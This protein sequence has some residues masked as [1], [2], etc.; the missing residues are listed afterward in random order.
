MPRNRHDRSGWERRKPLT[1][2]VL[3][4]STLAGLA[5]AAQAPDDRPPRSDE[6]PAGVDPTEY[7]RLRRP[8]TWQDLPQF[9]AP[10]SLSGLSDE[11]ANAIRRDFAERGRIQVQSDRYLDYDE[12]RNIIYSNA[13]TRVRFDKY[14]LEADRMLVH[15]PLQ[16][17]QAEGNVILRAW[18]DPE[19]KNKTDEIYCNSIVF[20]YKYYQGAASEA[21]GQHDMVYFKCVSSPSGLPGLQLI[22]RDEAIF[23]NAQFTTCD[24]PVPHYSAST[25]DGILIANDRIFLRNAVIRVRN[26]PVLWLPAYS[27]SINETMPWHITFGNTSRLG[28]YMNIAYNFWHY[29][30]EP[31][32]EKKDEYEV[33]DHGHAQARLDLFSRRGVGMGFF[34]NYGFDFEKHEGE[35]AAYYLPSDRYRQV[36]GDNNSSRWQLF[37]RHRSEIRKNLTFL[38]NVD[39][40]SDPEFYYDLS[41]PM[42]KID[43]GRIPERRA[44]AALTYWK[45]DYTARALFE[46]KQR[47]TRD[48]ITNTLEPTD[49]DRDYDLFP[50]DP[51]RHKFKDSQGLPSSRYGTVSARMPQLTFGTNL[52]RIGGNLPLYYM[53]DINAFNNLDKGLNFRSTRDD[54]YVLGFDLYQQI[55]YLF[56]LSERYTLLAQLG[57]GLGIEQRMDNSWNYR[58]SDFFLPDELFPGPLGTHHPRRDIIFVDPDTFVTPGGRVVSLRDVTPGFVYADAQLRA[59][60]RFTDSLTGNLNYIFREGTKNSLSQFYESIGN[61]TARVDL[62]DYRLRTNWLYGDLTY[63]LAYPDITTQLSAG[64]NLQ[65]RSD[66]FANQLIQFA[67]FGTQFRNQARTFRLSGTLRYEQ[68]QIRNIENP[69]QYQRDMAIAGLTAAYMPIHH[70]WWVEGDI[71]AIKP[72]TSDPNPAA[73]VPPP[74][75]TQFYYFQENQTDVIMDAWVGRKLSDKWTTEV[76]V[77]YHQRYGGLRDFRWIF[78][79][80][81]HDAVAQVQLRYR[82]SYLKNQPPDVGV[83]FN[84]TFKLPGPMETVVSPRANTLMMEQRAIEI[85]EDNLSQAAKE[86]A[87]RASAAPGSSL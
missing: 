67:G 1:L 56:K 19:L 20:N 28:P 76:G 27:R 10:E 62:Y 34:Y 32:F 59:R 33:R 82:R 21:R 30:Y 68:R 42:E 4:F 78:S 73:H 50:D 61:K 3:V 13:R 64:R 54:S 53:L 2:L 44:R 31:S 41:D 87:T 26:I 40:I 55:S 69:Y 24:F 70:R 9:L 18:S 80:D 15:V 17:I 22:G 47:I 65:S 49:D 38:L 16:E 14:I 48:R 52:L 75:H 51:T 11:V 84:I 83:H 35:F 46:V 60:G 66:I 5:A 37:A 71:F 7:D 29:R 57:A 86:A 85:A 77:G 72:L 12:E 36:P 39:Y 8:T 74:H 43:R 63:A 25:K 58:E 6:V 79:R 23:R 45:D 81:L